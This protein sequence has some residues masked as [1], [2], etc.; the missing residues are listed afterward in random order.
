MTQSKFVEQVEQRGSRTN[1]N[2]RT[3]GKMLREEPVTC[4]SNPA[5]VPMAQEKKDQAPKVDL[6]AE[7]LSALEAARN[8]K[9]GAE[10]TEAMKR[11]GI[12]RN[13]A[14]LQGLFFAKRGRPAKT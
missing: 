4:I 6:D 11:A 14:D 1:Y 13:A 8:M 9:P 7:A 12:L 3:S 2:C 10:R 5:L